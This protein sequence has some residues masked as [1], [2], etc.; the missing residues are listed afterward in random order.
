MSDSTELKP[1]PFCGSGKRTAHAF[2]CGPDDSWTAQVQCGE[3]EARGPEDFW[4]ETKEGAV[5]A[6]IHQWNKAPRAALPEAVPNWR[7]SKRA[8]ISQIEK[9][10]AELPEDWYTARSELHSVI[11]MV[12]HP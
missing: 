5:Q 1:C 7:K 4:H 2:A 8:L 11:D 12:L 6:A 10:I 9:R 3:C